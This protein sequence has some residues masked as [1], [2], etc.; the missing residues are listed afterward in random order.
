MR[1][2]WRWVYLKH[3]IEFDYEEHEIGGFE[4]TLER[5]KSAIENIFKDKK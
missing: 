5:A 3:V 4:D 2:L 1:G